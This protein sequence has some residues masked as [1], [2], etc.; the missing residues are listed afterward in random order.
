MTK[1]LANEQPK[2]WQMNNQNFGKSLTKILVN[3]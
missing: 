1:I 2:F 3:L